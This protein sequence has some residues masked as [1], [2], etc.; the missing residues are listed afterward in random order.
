[1]ATTVGDNVGVLAGD[2]VRLVVVV[3]EL[4]VDVGAA[5]GIMFGDDV[6]GDNVV[7]LAVG[8]MVTGSNSMLE[9]LWAS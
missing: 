6:M 7:G 1:V 3:V 8:T 2:L 4:D 9:A 5:D